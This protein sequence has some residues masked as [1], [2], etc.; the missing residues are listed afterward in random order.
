LRAWPLEANRS[1][2]DATP[3]NKLSSASQ[4]ENRYSIPDDVVARKASFIQEELDWPWWKVCVP[5]NDED[6]VE[7][8]RYL[9][10]TDY[11]DNQKALITAIVLRFVALY[12]EWYEQLRVS[13]LQ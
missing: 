1:D 2:G 11:R 6:E 4:E 8:R 7:N 3:V 9:A 13:D 12:R 5:M 10:L